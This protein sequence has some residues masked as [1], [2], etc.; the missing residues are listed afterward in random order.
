MDLNISDDFQS[1]GLPVGPVLSGSPLAVCY[2]V[3]QAC[4]MRVLLRP[5]VTHSS[6][7]SMEND[8]LR[9]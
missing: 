9:L 5:E 4:R 3:L 6:I 7:S 2:Q 8:S 1:T